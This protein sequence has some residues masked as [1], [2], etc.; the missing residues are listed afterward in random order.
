M[1]TNHP[2]NFEV[3]IDRDELRKYFGHLYRQNFW[4]LGMVFGLLA[5][6][7]SLAVLFER[8]AS[9]MMF[10]SAGLIVFLLLAAASISSVFLVWLVTRTAFLLHGKKV[11]EKRAGAYRVEVEGPF[12]RVIDGKSDRKIHFRQIG[13]Y[14]AVL[15][16][17]RKPDVGTIRMSGPSGANSVSFLLIWAVKDVL[18]M[19][20][21]LAE[22]D[23]ER[24]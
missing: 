23:A 8:L 20:D 11:T 21:L 14:E 3:E 15:G 6:L 22:V 10:L 24:E 19:R 1:K 9:S 17:K 13:D 5:A 2:E 7:G 4:A 16:N 12:L 18:K